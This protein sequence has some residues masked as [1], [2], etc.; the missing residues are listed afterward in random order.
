M[1][2]QLAFGDLSPKVGFKGD[3]ARIN[4]DLI[5]VPAYQVTV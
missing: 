4:S 2:L 5:G 3:L 1:E